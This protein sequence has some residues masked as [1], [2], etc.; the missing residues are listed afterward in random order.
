ICGGRRGRGR[1][2]MKTMIGILLAVSSW[3]GVPS[4]MAQYGDFKAP[5]GSAAQVNVAAPASPAATPSAPIQLQT[6]DPALTAQQAST[7]AGQADNAAFVAAQALDVAAQAASTLG[8]GS[9]ASPP[10]RGT[11]ISQAG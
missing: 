7:L 6:I 9:S 8:A 3:F 11:G 4:A 5:M 10:F 2:L 1:S